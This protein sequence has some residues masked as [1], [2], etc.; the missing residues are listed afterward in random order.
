[1]TSVMNEIVARFKELPKDEQTALLSKL[2]EQSKPAVTPITVDE[3]AQKQRVIDAT[4]EIVEDVKK[5]A[6]KGNTNKIYTMDRDIRRDIMDALE[7]YGIYQV[8][9]SK[10]E[11][12]GTKCDVKLTWG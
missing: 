10:I 4:N 6:A 7:P 8:G 11:V 9:L 12:Y 5:L 2:Q 1:M 3:N